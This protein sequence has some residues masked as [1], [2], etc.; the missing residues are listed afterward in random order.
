MLI[1]LRGFPFAALQHIYCSAQYSLSPAAAN[2][3][4]VTL[5]TT[6]AHLGCTHCINCSNDLVNC[7]SAADV[8]R[9]EDCVR[10]P[11]QL[12]FLAL[13]PSLLNPLLL[14]LVL[15][16]DH[17]ICLL[18]DS[19]CFHLPNE[20]ETFLYISLP[21]GLSPSTENIHGLAANVITIATTK[22]TTE[23]VVN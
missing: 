10:E 21:W 14:S 16:P 6:S 1:N 13:S 4:S 17:H 15:S 12:D 7:L 3:P 11:L 18:L 20:K 23:N 8:R 9:R 22:A 5:A 2:H 19:V